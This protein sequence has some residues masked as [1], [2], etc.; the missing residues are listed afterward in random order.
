MVIIFGIGTLSAGEQ[1]TM[2]ETEELKKLY[3]SLDNK[4]SILNILRA[5]RYKH[6]VDFLNRSF[7]MLADKKYSIGMKIYWF[8]NGIRD[9]PRCREC[10]GPNKTNRCHLE[11]GYITEYC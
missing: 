9:F 5:E 11:E 1:D 3:E 4:R 10:G 8:L 7:P 2:S 6:L